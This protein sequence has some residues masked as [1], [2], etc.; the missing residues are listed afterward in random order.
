MSDITKFSSVR[1]TAVQTEGCYLD[2]QASVEKTYRLI[3]EAAEKGCDLIT[4]PE[5]WI[6]MDPGWTM[7]CPSIPI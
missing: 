4:F 5:V 2:L 6:P 7:V 3:T 1:V